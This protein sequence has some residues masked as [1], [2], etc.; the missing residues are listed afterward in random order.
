MSTPSRFATTV[1]ALKHR[2][3][4]LWFF[5]QGLSLIGTWMQ[6]MA[7]Q[8]LVYRLTGSASALGIVSFVQVLPLLPFA[9]WGGT[10]ADRLPKRTLILVTQSLML[11]QALVLALLTWTGVIEIWHVY[12]MAFLL[13]AAKAVDMPARQSFVVEMVEGRED[14]TSA[15]GL[16]SAIHNTARTLGPALAGVAVATMGEAVA[17]FLNGLSFLAVIAS[18]LMMRGLPHIVRAGQDEPP[19]LSHVWEGV[20][21]VLG[22]QTLLV[23]MSLVAVSS[24]LARP[25]QTLMP[26]F[27]DVLLKGSAQP[28]VAF[29]CD[30]G[31]HLFNCRAPEALP[32]GLLLSAVGVGAVSG[33]VLVASLPE[34]ARR[35][36]WLTLGNLALPAL[37]LGFVNSRS[38]L[39][40]LLLLLF[41]GMGQVFQNSLANTLVQI[42]APDALRGRVMSQY[43][44][45]SQGMHHLGGLQAGFLADWI[46]APLSVGI[47]AAASLAYGLFVALRY[48]RVRALT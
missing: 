43:A 39:L 3:Y 17:F 12:L 38:F 15:I 47:G 10:L 33:A 2:N 30:G 8:V 28:V 46:G 48:P 25:Y 27:A 40:S 29:L 45:V 32:L 13:G 22:Q 36:R 7:Q 1:R 37:L 34:R 9:L 16:N 23:L 11:V 20:R 18:L 4:Q 21:Y 41:V 26:V 44:L 6:S 14:L 24:F 35:G 42:T 19:V 5:G 31:T